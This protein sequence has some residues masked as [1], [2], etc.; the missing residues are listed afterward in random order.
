MYADTA[1][2]S[3][4]QQR[5]SETEGALR[6]QL[7]PAI[8]RWRMA[9]A[10]LE[11]LL[12]TERKALE[13]ARAMLVSMQGR[14]DARIE[15]IAALADLLQG[16]GQSPKSADNTDAQRKL[17]VST[18]E[19]ATLSKF[20]RTAEDNARWLGDVHNVLMSYPSWWRFM[21]MRWQE[22][23]RSERLRQKGLFDADA[24]LKRYPDIA[25]EGMDP[26]RHYIMH[27]QA[28]GRLR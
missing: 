5:L 19:I 3:K 21:P 2:L 17:D 1:E 27:G 23:K 24:Y 11:S 22:R 10:E 8:E 25:Q 13:D 20:L 18:R 14:L 9:A 12:A 4:L 16:R 28:E 6:P 7:E 26:L 15:E